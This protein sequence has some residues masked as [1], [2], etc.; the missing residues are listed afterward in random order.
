MAC[1]LLVKCLFEEA[2]AF[3]YRGKSRICHLSNV[4]AG[5]AT[6]S[7]LNCADWLKIF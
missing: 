3:Q 5:R 4:G 6:M 7:D 2:L 1:W